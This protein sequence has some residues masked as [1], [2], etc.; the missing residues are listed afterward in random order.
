MESH[1]QAHKA[2]L[3]QYIARQT[4]DPAVAEDILHDVY[5]KAHTQMGS[6]KSENSI[7]SWLYRIAHN[8]IMDY[9]RQQKPL[10]E[11]PDVLV[12]PET[13]NAEQAHQELA[14]CLVPL[15]NELPEKYRLPLQMSELEGK[16]QQE[17]AEH[18]E[19]SLSGA[20]SRIQ[21]GRALLKERFTLCCDIETGQ[22]GV[23]DFEL[24]KPGCGD[25]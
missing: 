5:I 20:K 8:S 25:C 24:K 19:L 12:A 3:Q 16:K 7:G 11:L 9:F 1:W 10:E 17:V 21:R 2:R 15:M 14:R 22:G 6:L 4:G 13:D 18:L 23:L